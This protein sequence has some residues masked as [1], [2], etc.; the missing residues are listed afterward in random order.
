MNKEERI[1]E[2]VEDIVDS[3]DWDTLIDYARDKMS[4]HYSKLDDEELRET[5]EGHFGETYEGNEIPKKKEEVD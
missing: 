1:N 4:K 3:W 2:L 5:W